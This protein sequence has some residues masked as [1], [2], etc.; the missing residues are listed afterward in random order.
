MGFVE[1]ACAK[2]NIESI[3]EVGISG[4]KCSSPQVINALFD[5]IGL[6]I[7]QEIGLKKLALSFDEY[8]SNTI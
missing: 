3:T 5:D 7:D 2:K 1:D 8:E 6:N 4:I